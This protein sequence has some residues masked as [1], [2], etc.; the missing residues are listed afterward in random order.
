MPMA[1]NSSHWP[2]LPG[3][4]WLEGGAFRCPVSGQRCACH[5]AQ[6][7]QDQLPH[8]FQSLLKCHLLIRLSLIALLNISFLTIPHPIPLA[9]HS[10]PP[11]F[12]S[13][14]LYH[15]AWDVSSFPWGSNLGIELNAQSPNHWTAKEFPP[16]S[17][18]S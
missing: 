4:S 6:L 18:K 2:K 16:L 1:L 3:F 13:F 9:L 11:S 14:W 7:P 8:L 5:P 17:F 12:S 10:T 15:M